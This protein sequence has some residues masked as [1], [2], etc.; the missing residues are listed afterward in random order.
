MLK[1]QQLQDE[2]K[3][4]EVILQNLFSF[5]ASHSKVVFKKHLQHLVA[6]QKNAPAQF[7]SSLFTD[8]GEPM[9]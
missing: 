7:L 5:F 2:N 4:R 3:K 6:K 8:D 9:L 1:H